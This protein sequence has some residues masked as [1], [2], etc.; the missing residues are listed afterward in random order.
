MGE[1][2]A[3]T[4][5]MYGN[6]FDHFAV[7]YEYAG[8]QRVL[9]MCRQTAGASGRVSEHLVGTEGLANPN[10]R[11][12]GAQPFEWVWPE[13]V[14]VNPYVQE[15]HDLIASIRHRRPLNEGRRVAESTMTAIMGRMSAYT[16][17]I[18]KW[19]DAVEKGTSE[20]PEQLAW[21]APAPVQKD[22]AGNYPIPKPGV[23]K[24]Y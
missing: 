13:G 12:K 23:Y 21:D 8:G 20:F 18:V 9:S 3:R 7:E 1:R 5:P 16:G 14:Q 2:Q 17:K 10:G 22:E 19:D 4:S 6:I 15:H 24:A 11:I